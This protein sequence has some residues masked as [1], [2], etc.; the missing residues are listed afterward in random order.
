MT[1]PS[2]CQQL[3]SEGITHGAVVHRLSLS[4]GHT[5]SSAWNRKGPRNGSS[6]SQDSSTLKPHWPEHVAAP[7]RRRH[8]AA[9]GPRLEHHKHTTLLLSQMQWDPSSGTHG[10]QAL[11]PFLGAKVIFIPIPHLLFFFWK[12]TNYSKE[13]EIRVKVKTLGQTHGELVICPALKEH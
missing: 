9:E 10:Q 1:Q 13:K 2:R 4:P 7:W 6:K 5:H 3:C 8:R 11:M 12:K